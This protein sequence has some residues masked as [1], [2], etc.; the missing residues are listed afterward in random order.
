MGS[1]G[2]GGRAHCG[3]AAVLDG[4][5][6]LAEA[7]AARAR[8]DGAA[9]E[10]LVARARALLPA[11]KRNVALRLMEKIAARVLQNAIERDALP[12]Q[13]AC[14]PAPAASLDQLEVSPDGGWFR[15]G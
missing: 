6:W 15:I 11:G 1:I 8:G 5:H 10:H 3:G 2:R 14:A 13:A 9:A 7:R 4:V 12:T